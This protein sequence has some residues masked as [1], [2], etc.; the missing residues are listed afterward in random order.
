MLK[1]NHSDS[2]MC[3]ASKY[4]YTKRSIK[5]RREWLDTLKNRPCTRCGIVYPPYVT[6]W[7][8]RDKK[9]KKF[10]IGKGSF[11]QSKKAILEEIEKCDLYCANCHRIIEYE[12]NKTLFRKGV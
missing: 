5:L 12:V 2:G 8:H 4:E 11:R 3:M 7:H 1:I 6:D 9:D 10:G